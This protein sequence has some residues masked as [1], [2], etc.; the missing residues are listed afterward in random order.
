M[1]RWPRN[2][3]QKSGVNNGIGK[4]MAAKGTGRGRP[5][6]LKAEESGEEM[7]C[8]DEEMGLEEN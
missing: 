5:R 7:G 4:S 8:K 1:N 6:K 2:G 3:A